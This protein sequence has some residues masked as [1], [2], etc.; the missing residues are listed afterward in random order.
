MKLFRW[1]ELEALLGP[2]GTIVAASAAGLLPSIELD[3]PELAEF[4]VRTELALAEE[5]GAISSGQHI[6]AVLRKDA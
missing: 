5:P 4:V 1:S 6:V 2:H 3:D